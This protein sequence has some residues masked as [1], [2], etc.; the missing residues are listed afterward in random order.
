M[1]GGARAPGG[2]TI[3]MTAGG[4]R[5]RR[6]W[7]GSSSCAGLAATITDFRGHPDHDAYVKAL[8]DKHKYEWSFWTKVKK[9]FVPSADERKRQASVARTY[10]SARPSNQRDA[11]WRVRPTR[12]AR[13]P[14]HTHCTLPKHRILTETRCSESDSRR[15]GPQ[16]LPCRRNATLRSQIDYPNGLPRRQRIESDSK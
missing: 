4:S 10:G 9:R 14:L 8:H 13:L 2:S 5:S 7:P 1:S 12:A 6:P 16:L 3:H 15:G 11:G